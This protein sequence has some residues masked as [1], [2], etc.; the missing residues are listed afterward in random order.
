MKMESA[1]AEA[2][3][4]AESAET[5]NQQQITPAQLATLA[6]VTDCAFWVGIVEAEY[7]C[8]LCHC[9]IGHS[10]NWMCG[11]VNRFSRQIDAWAASLG[12]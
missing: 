8:I 9:G 2:Q 1:A 10:D 6:Q 5:E 7:Y 4:T 12:C 3:Q 11:D